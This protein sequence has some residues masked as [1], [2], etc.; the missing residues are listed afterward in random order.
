LIDRI[1]KGTGATIGLTVTVDGTATDPDPDSATVVVTN[2]AGETLVASAPATDTGTG[3]FSYNLTP[4]HTATLDTLTAT[5]SYVRDGNTETQETTH[6]IVGGFLFTIAEARA[7]PPLDSVSKYPTAAIVA[8]RTTVEDAIEHACGC[9][10]APRYALETVSGTGSR[11]MLLRPLVSRLRSVTADSSAWSAGELAA[12]SLGTTG[13]LYSAGRSWAA[14]TNN[15]VVG[16]EHGYQSPPPEVKRAALILLKTWLV[17][18]R[19][20][21]DD[22]AATFNVTEGGTYSLVVPGR[23]GSYFGQPDVDAVIDRYS[24]RTGIA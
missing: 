5:W 12:V 24:L 10:F 4:A 20:P 14:G 18:Q 6:E 21:V 2:T 7:I 22:R 11:D 13:S 3:S 8:M 17:G 15:I 19:S 16:Y 9:A 1:L 23:N